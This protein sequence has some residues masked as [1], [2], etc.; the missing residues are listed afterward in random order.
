MDFVVS[1]A[2]STVT[3]STVTAVRTQIHCYIVEILIIVLEVVFNGRRYV[4]TIHLRSF[5]VCLS[6]L[7]RDAPGLIKIPNEEFLTEI[8]LKRSEE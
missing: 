7:I 4:S 8:N 3:V 6:F 1:L 2:I 5:A